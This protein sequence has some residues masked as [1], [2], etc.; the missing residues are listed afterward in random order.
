MLNIVPEETEITNLTLGTNE[1][2]PLHTKMICLDNH[3][4]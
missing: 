2:T 3:K 1:W 4:V